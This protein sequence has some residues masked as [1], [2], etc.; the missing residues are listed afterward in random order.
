ML[1]YLVANRKNNKF[2]DLPMEERMMRQ[3]GCSSCMFEYPNGLIKTTY[4]KQKTCLV[5]NSIRLA[6]FLTKYLDGLTDGKIIYHT[7]LTVRNPG[8][9]NLRQTINKMFKF[10]NNSSIKKDKVFRRLNKLVGMIRSFETTLNEREKTY[11]I[12]FHILLSS[13][14]EK[15]II[16][17]GM[18]LKKYWLKYFGNKAVSYAPAIRFARSDKWACCAPNNFPSPHYQPPAH[19]LNKLSLDRRSF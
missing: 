15:D 2:K 5:C 7:V 1:A 12:H 3:L 17:Y 14:N 6:K 9:E 11:H 13:N 19:H 18:I 16:A 4:C 8:R 10:F